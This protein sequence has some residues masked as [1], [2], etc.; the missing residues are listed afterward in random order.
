MRRN[1]KDVINREGKPLLTVCGKKLDVLRTHQVPS[2][3]AHQL[4]IVHHLYAAIQ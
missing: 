4:H 2:I 1:P 3:F